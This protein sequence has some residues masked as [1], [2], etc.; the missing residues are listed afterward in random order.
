MKF[1]L[2]QGRTLRAFASGSCQTRMGAAKRTR[3]EWNGKRLF[4][5]NPFVNRPSQSPRS[6][7]AKREWS[8]LHDRSDRRT[9][10]NA[11]GG[12]SGRPSKKTERSEQGHPTKN[13][14]PDLRTDFW[15][16]V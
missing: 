15:Q 2:L 5:Q 8:G 14:P 1:A 13:I 7:G 10:I 3:E 4:A 6:Q 16:T 9:G 12:D 11:G